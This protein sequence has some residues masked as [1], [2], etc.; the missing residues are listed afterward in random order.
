MQSKMIYVY[1]FVGTLVLAE[2][3]M[4]LVAMVKPEIFE[5]SKATADSTVVAADQKHAPDTS[6]GVLPDTVL[7]EEV[8]SI[9]HG[10]ANKESVTLGQKS[11]SIALL[12]SK[13]KATEKRLAELEPSSRSTAVPVLVSDSA[14]AK[15]RKMLIKMLETMSAESAARIVESFQDPDAKAILMGIKAKQA[16]K[17]LGAINAD[18]A[19]KLMR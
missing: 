15:D 6:H 18:R 11:D 3:V 7:K 19:S 17:I 10:D 2:V 12:L 16:G 5:G 1:V 13:L 4:M 14:K 8:T 9:L